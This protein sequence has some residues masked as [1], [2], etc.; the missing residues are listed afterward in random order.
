M[1]VC[2]VSLK[3][4]LSCKLMDEVCF[5]LKNCVLSSFVFDVCVHVYI[6]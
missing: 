3:G 5:V 2:E 1:Y 6:I 4:L